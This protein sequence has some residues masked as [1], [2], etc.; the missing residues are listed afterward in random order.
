MQDGQ[1]RLR[2]GRVRV[3]LLLALKVIEVHRAARRGNA[4]QAHHAGILALTQERHQQAGQRE[5]PQVVGGQLK[6]KA[7]GGCTPLGR[8]H[9]G[10]IVDQHV[11]ARQP[12]VETLG[13]VAHR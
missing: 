13:Q 10:G 8:C 1:F 5:V 11:E 2:V 3:V 6:F 4:G 9:D 12:L 7:I